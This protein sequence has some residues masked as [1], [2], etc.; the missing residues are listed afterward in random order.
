ME[1]KPWYTSK[2]I[3]LN[4]VTA[5]TLILMLFA[6]GA[7]FVGLLTPTVANYLAL[8][9]A[10]LNIVVRVFFTEAPIE[11]PITNP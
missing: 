9:V 1:P 4:I 11:N 8:A 5:A 7:P 6:P 3:W 2:A 10:V